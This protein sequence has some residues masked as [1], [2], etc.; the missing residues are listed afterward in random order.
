MAVVQIGGVYRV[1]KADI[2][3]LLDSEDLSADSTLVS[4]SIEA[5]GDLTVSVTQDI[6]AEPEPEV[7]PT[8]EAND[9]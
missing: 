7:E 8:P 1:D 2:F 4:A 9:F 5:S 6:P 3:T